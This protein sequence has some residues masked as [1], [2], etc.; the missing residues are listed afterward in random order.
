MHKFQKNLFYIHFVICDIFVKN[1]FVI[2]NIRDVKQTQIRG[3]HPHLHPSQWVKTRVDWVCIFLKIWTMLVP[4]LYY[5]CIFSVLA[6]DS[7]L[8]GKTR[9]QRVRVWVL[10]YYPN[11]LWVWIRVRVMNSS[12]S[13]GSVKPAHVGTRCHPYSI[14]LFL[15]VLLFS[16]KLIFV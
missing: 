16:K 8:G 2:Y 13:L 9:T 6:T 10:F 4:K 5:Y 12:A 3:A 7:G 11:S 1:W 14:S 15:R